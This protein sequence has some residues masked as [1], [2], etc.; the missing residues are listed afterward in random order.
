MIAQTQQFTLTSG[1]PKTYYDKKTDS[2]TT[3]GRHF[4]GSCGSNL[5]ATSPVV[6]QILVLFS[7]SLDQAATWW[8]PN[9]GEQSHVEA[10]PFL[11]S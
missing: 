5:F 10:V 11:T 6:E 7:G 3:L 2:G 9:K 8:K 4:C 1:T